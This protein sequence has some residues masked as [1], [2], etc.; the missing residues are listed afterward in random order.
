MKSERPKDPGPVSSN[1]HR[2]QILVV[3]DHADIAQT[4][5]L[6]LRLRG[7][8]V[9]VAPDGPA[10]LEAFRR[11][12]RDVVLLDNGLPQMDGYEVARRLRAMRPKKRLLIIAVTG[13]GQEDDRRRS[14]EAGID[15]HLVKPADPK[16]LLNLLR[17][18]QT[19]YQPSVER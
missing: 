17:E 7:F 3:E 13:Y 1:G 18:V 16:V 19:I 15:L 10:A 9:E 5:A 6:L 4:T 14:V 2:L 11:A 8:Q 12:P